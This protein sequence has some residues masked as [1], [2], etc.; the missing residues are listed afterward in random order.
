MTSVE[1]KFEASGPDIV[2]VSDDLCW[3][4]EC[5]GC[6]TG[7]PSTQRNNFDRALASAVSCYEDRRPV[8][9]GLALPASEQYKKLLETRAGTPLR[10]RLN[11]WVLL[12]DHGEIEPIR[13]NDDYPW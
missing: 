1:P 5:K 4:I 8:T 9:L 3:K 11:L 10:T 6:G 13:P 7:K 12:Y 2:V